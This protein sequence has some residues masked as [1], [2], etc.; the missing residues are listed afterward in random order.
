MPLATYRK[1]RDFRLTPEP[2]GLKGRSKST[3]HYVIQKHAATRLHYD[4]RL[5]LDGV[6]KSWAVPKGPSLDPNQK[7]LAV[8]VEDHPL[9]YGAFEG[10]IPAGQYGGGTV[11]L[12][13]RGTWTPIGDPQAGLRKGHLA[14]ELQGKKLRG[15]FSLIRMRGDDEAKKNWL[16]VKQRDE[17][18]RPER[19]GG[20]VEELPLSVLSGKAIEQIAEARRGKVWN[21]DRTETAPTETARPRAKATR[22]RPR[23]VAPDPA[24]LPG[25]R[26]APMPARV[27]PELATL[28]KQPPTGEEWLH[29][30]KFDGYRAL[31]R[32]ERGRAAMITRGGQDWTERFVTIADAMA[33]L[34]AESALVDGEVAV[35]LPDG[36]T[37]FQS[38]QNQLRLGKDA[39]LAYFVFD[40][41][42]LDGYDLTRVP[43]RLRK[44]TLERLVSGAGSPKPPGSGDIVRYSDHVVGQGD[45][46]HAE[47]CRRGLE[48]IV[49]KQRDSKYVPG[50]SGLWV[51]TKCS[52]R[53]EFVIGGYTEPQGSRA[54]PG[55]LLLGTRDNGDGLRYRGRVGTGF[56]QETLRELR[57]KLTR[58]ETKASPFSTPPRIRGAHWVRPRIVAEVSFGSWT[59]DGKLRHPSFVGLRDDKP[60]SE[61]VREKPSSARAAG[62]VTAR[63]RVPP[64]RRRPPDTPTR[65]PPPVRDPNPKPPVADPPQKPS[66]RPIREPLD[67]AALSALGLT[68]SDR[69]L[70][71]EQGLTKVDL[72]RYLLLVAPSLLAHA[73][74]RPLMLLRCPAGR[75]KC[76]FQKHPSGE[77]PPS[78]DSVRIR[79]K[80]KTETYLV[81][82]DE[83]SLV[84]IAQ[85]GV[86]E[87]HVWGARAND[88]ERPDRVVF[89]FDPHESTPW[90]DVI[91][92]ATRVRERL[93]DLGLESFVKTTG[94]KGLHVVVPTKP[95]PSWDDLKEFSAAIAAAMVRDEPDR[96]T[97]HLAKARRGNRIFVDTL[98]NGRGAT[99]VA[100]YSPRARSGAPVSTPIS[101][102]ELT[103]RMRPET[104]NVARILEEGSGRMDA[105]EGMKAVRQTL[106]TSIVRRARAS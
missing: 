72:A 100:A 11:L 10:T 89:D 31:C 65:L 20:V 44:E 56:T 97:T 87:L 32:V 6:L 18:A 84:T 105:W 98:R 14:F 93:D 92:G 53:Q 91:H 27:E 8:E 48:G 1:K 54:G 66:K 17:W 55:A 26:R 75:T 82:R 70:Y 78:L 69:V 102:E 59:D 22:T 28:V 57:Q 7:R 34:G 95:S 83:E 43:L 42:H 25:A 4:F 58:L 41:L 106:T 80:Q 2:R 49:S 103:S 3:L 86:L 23:G 73:A 67:K 30:I 40:L 94:G 63:K 38:L 64:A 39:T 35:V 85:M 21:S 36:S 104:F 68:H 81:L 37:S 62:G 45:R 16:L 9:D 15:G 71:P 101:W 50:R 90:K 33:A 96:F 99:W 5:E 46:F 12:W 52:S 24:S 88:L 60:A 77:V 76:F 19:R 74:G 47:A 79:E 29:E 13:D 61:V 51:K